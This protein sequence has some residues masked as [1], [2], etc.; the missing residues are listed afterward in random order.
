M[1]QPEPYPNSDNH[2]V[3]SIVKGVDKDVERCEDTI[4]LGY[5]LV[6]MA[7]IFAPI[8]PPKIL[9]PLMALAFILSVCRARLNFHIIRAKLTASMAAH[10]GCDFSVLAPLLA[11][12]KQYPE[13]TL[14]EAFNPLK[15]LLRTA[16]SLLGALMINPFWLPVFYALGMQFAEEK[17]VQQLN[18]AVVNLEKKTAGWN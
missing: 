18:K 1:S 16:K 15:N 3:V 11:V 17:Q 10:E 4:M 2:P 8:A 6:L 13:H 9:L 12:F 5:A 14:T 7:P